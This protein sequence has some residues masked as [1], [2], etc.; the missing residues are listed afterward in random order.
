MQSHSSKNTFEE[1][2]DDLVSHGIRSRDI[3]GIEG[4][5]QVSKQIYK[6]LYKES[7]LP[8]IQP[9]YKI[10][11]PFNKSKY[12]RQQTRTSATPRYRYP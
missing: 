12:Q 5:K 9:F 7:R 10:Q 8:I 2:E 1:A 6:I 3:L 11:N 4:I